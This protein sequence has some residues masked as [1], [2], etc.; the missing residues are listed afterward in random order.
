M[1]EL[2]AKLNGVTINTKYAES[3]S[4][5]VMHQFM[6]ESGRKVPRNLRQDVSIEVK[7]TNPFEGSIKSVD[8]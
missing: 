8:K 6:F 7:R 2:R 4:P 5:L 3:Q 1:Y